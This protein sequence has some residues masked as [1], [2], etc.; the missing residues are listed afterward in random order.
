MNSRKRA[1]KKR[2]SGYCY[3]RGASHSRE[4]NLWKPG[5]SLTPQDLELLS[6]LKRAYKK[7]AYVPSQK[8]V[9]NAPAIK[10]RFRTWGDALSAAGLPRYNDSDQVYLRQKKQ[11]ER[12]SEEKEQ[13]DL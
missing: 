9:S 4:P 11:A 8:E 13:T 5:E 1:K 10:K 3:K 7:L 2:Q 6:E 12:E